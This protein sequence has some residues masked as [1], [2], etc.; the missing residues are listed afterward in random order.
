MPNADPTIK[1]GKWVRW[2]DRQPSTGDMPRGGVYLFEYFMGDPPADPR[3][4]T[5]THG[6][7]ALAGSGRT[8]QRTPSSKTQW[9]TPIV[10]VMIAT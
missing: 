4:L 3:H 1:F 10:G 2:K 8:L 7:R 5:I 9:S 6:N